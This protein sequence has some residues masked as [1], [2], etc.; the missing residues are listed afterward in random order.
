[1][2]NP[3]RKKKQRKVEFEK[4]QKLQDSQEDISI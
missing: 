2:L 3:L 1:M 4:T